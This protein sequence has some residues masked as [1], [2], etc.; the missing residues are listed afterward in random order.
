MNEHEVIKHCQAGD[1][2][3]FAKLFEFYGSK[4]LKTAFLITRNTGLA[5][6]ATQEAFI[7]CF[8]HIGKL[9]NPATF[10][11]WFYRLLVR[12]CWRQSGI[13]RKHAH[14]GTDSINSELHSCGND[15]T[16]ELDRRNT[17]QV[18]QA[19]LNRLDQPHRTVIILYYFNELSVREIARCLGC[20]EGTVK[21]RLFTARKRLE[22]ELLGAEEHIRELGFKLNMKGSI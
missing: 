20:F 13:E 15:F 12:I 4:A 14:L 21:S 16:D 17:Y 1:E 22:K 3:A 9:R 6:E 8:R 10:Q 2:H 18:V 19:A 7:Q 11:A 5:E